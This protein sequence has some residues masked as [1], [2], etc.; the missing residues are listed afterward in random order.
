MLT[1]PRCHA[2]QVILSLAAAKGARCL[3]CGTRWVQDGSEQRN[4]VG[5]AVLRPGGRP[6]VTAPEPT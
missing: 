4:V 2:A 6:H 5:P 1:C 3:V